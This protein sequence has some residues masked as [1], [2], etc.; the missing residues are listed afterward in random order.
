MGRS[1]FFRPFFC[2]RLELRAFWSSKRLGE[3]R[4]FYLTEIASAETMS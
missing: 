3:E 1:S 2:L 4:Q